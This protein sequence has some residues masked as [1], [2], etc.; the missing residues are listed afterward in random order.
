MLRTKLCV[1]QFAEL[2]AQ[3]APNVIV[4]F[5]YPQSPGMLRYNTVDEKSGRS[6][7][8]MHGLWE[9]LS[10]ICLSLFIL[11]FILLFIISFDYCI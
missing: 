7:D 8:R 10:L 11:S 4:E 6:V 9:I 5:I 2:K 1:I 3:S